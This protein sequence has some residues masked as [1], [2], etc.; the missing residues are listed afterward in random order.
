MI[1]PMTISLFKKKNSKKYRGRALKTIFTEGPAEADVKK[2]LNFT[3]KKKV[4]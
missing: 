3:K 4:V 2:S 1:L